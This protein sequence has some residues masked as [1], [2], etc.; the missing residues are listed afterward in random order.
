MGATRAELPKSS[1]TTGTRGWVLPTTKVT[2]NKLS[3]DLMTMLGDSFLMV[4]V[5]PGTRGNVPVTVGFFPAGLCV[6]PSV[7]TK[8]PLF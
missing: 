3:L 1:L 7:Q 8:N 2:T 6:E 4:K 5:A